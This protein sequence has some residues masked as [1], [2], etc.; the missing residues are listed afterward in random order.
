MVKRPCETKQFLEFDLSAG[1]DGCLGHSRHDP[2]LRYI[3]IAE[4]VRG[5]KTSSVRHRLFCPRKKS[6]LV[7]VLLASASSMT[8][9]ETKQSRP[10][11]SNSIRILL[12]KS[13]DTRAA[14]NSCRNEEHDGGLIGW[15][16]ECTECC[17][18]AL[19]EGFRT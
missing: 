14:A 2:D 1:S 6:F 16:N 8:H 10:S 19:A 9:A 13:S 15:Q 12:H 4:R 17:M 7:G 11:Q 18:A 5:R 3:V